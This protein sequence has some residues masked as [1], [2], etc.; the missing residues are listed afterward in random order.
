MA[1]VGDVADTD[2]GVAHQVRRFPAGGGQVKTRVVAAIAAGVF[3]VVG[4]VVGF[5]APA[6]AAEPVEQACLGEFLSAGAQAFGVGFG[7]TIGS[8]AQNPEQAGLDNLGEGIQNL[9]A[10]TAPLFPDACNTD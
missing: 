1:F 2:G 9:Q 6:Q 4:F 3:G 5:A 7:Q 10:G 8:F